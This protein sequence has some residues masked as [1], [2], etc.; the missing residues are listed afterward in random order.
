MSYAKCLRCLTR[1]LTSNHNF[2]MITGGWGGLYIYATATAKLA[3]TLTIK[4]TN[5]SLH[6]YLS[7]DKYGIMKLK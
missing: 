4:R 6:Y 3:L 1:Y 2:T 5:L 7:C